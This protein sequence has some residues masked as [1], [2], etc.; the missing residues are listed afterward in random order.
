MK[1]IAVI[2]AISTWIILNIIVDY[3]VDELFHCHTIEEYAISYVHSLF[4]SQNLCEEFKNQGRLVRNFLR[5][6][7]SMWVG[8]ALV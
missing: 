7:I 2:L 5:F 8:N 3:M 1:V 6:C 4:T